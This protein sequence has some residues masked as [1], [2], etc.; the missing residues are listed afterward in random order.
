MK[1]QRLGLVNRVADDDAMDQALDELCAQ[2]LRHPQ[3]AVE[4]GKRMFYRQ[5]E[6][7]LADA[8]AYAAEAMACNMMEQDTLQGV[9]AFLDKRPLP[10]SD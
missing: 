7:G 1:S 9:Q 8:Y 4:T 10:W 5:L 2:I 6:H 3:V